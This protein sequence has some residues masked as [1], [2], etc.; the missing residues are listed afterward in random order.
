M[1][2]EMNLIWQMDFIFARMIRRDFRQ[3]GISL[4]ICAA[5]LNLPASLP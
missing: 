4:R 5:H 2:P 1:L 3:T